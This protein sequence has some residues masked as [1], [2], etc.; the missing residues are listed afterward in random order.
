MVNPMN[1]KD[2][3]MKR[4]A[5]KKFDG[6]QVPQKLVD[7]LL[8]LI[9]FAPSS[10]NL[11]PWKIKVIS[12][13][14]TKDKL[15]PASWNQEQIK[16]A[17]HV[18]VFC[19][20]T[21]LEPLAKKLA[22]AMLAAGVPEANVK[23]LMSYIDPFIAGMNEAQ[24]TAWAQRQVYLALENGLLGATALGFD[25]CPMEGFVPAEYSKIL[26]LPTHLVPTAVMPIGYAADKQ[27]AKVRFA[28]E[29]I[30]F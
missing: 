24:R 4:Y 17:S 22:E 28:K 2:I 14:A 10:Y 6:K 7:E 15:H 18:L 27:R 19:A 20:N 21:Q 3:V 11:Q 9:R 29:D 5:V 25:S 13:Q 1:F 16:T 30:F 12:D 23:G 8:E 26:K